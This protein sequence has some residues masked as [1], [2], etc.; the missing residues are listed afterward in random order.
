M[1][2]ATLDQRFPS[3]CASSDPFIT[4]EAHVSYTV[5]VIKVK[6]PRKMLI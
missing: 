6:S 4:K 5:K 3:G 1:T 2:A